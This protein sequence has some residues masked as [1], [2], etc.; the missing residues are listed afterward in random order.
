MASTNGA[1]DPLQRSQSTTPPASAHS[2]T[3][4]VPGV[5]G[6]AIP[7]SRAGPRVGSTSALSPP[8]SPPTRF[9]RISSVSSLFPTGRIP[10]AAASRQPS[11]PD[12][13]PPNP[14]ELLRHAPGVVKSRNGAVLSRGFMLKSDQRPTAPSSVH[15]ATTDGVEGGVHLRGATNFRMAELGVFGVAQPTET[16]LRTILSVLKSQNGRQTVWFCTREEP[17][18]YIGAQPFVLRDAAQ[19][20]RTYALS[21]RAENLEEIEMRLKQDIIKEAAR[22]G[23][24]ILVHEEIS[25]QQI[26]NTWVAVDQVR[27]VREVWEQVAAEGY[28]LVY[29]RI[30]VTRDQSPE[31]RYLDTYAE[32]LASIPTTSSLVFNC[33][34]GVVRTTFAMC[35]ALIVRRRQM[36]LQGMEDPYGIEDDT[37]GKVEE[38]VKAAVVLR[39]RSE[40]AIRDQSLLRL[41]HVLQKSLASQGQHTVL[42]LLSSQP[43]L[44]EN[45]RTALLGQY[46]IVLSLLS[47]LD[48]GSD[49]K[50]L[51][52]TVV[53]HSS[54]TTAYFFLIS[55]ASFAHDTNFSVK[56]STW[57]RERSE[58]AKMISRMRKTGHFF[59]FSPVHDLSQIAKGGAGQIAAS[60]GL[61]QDVQRNGGELIGDEWARQIVRNRSGIILRA[62]MILKNDQWRSMAEGQEPTIRGAINFR[63]VPNSSLYGLSQ[64]TQDGIERVLESVRRDNAGAKIVWINLREEPLLYIK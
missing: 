26:R 14:R 5:G 17:V 4:S 57:L 47:T 8:N 64:P 48:H 35:A 40:Q 59:V 58:V 28:N 20:T 30:P 39:A 27:T 51:V 10:S 41:M 33:G 50:R 6:V 16:G 32:I 62:G 60:E 53:D 3:V 29:H 43:Q 63:R 46:D 34:I 22:Y 9:T 21:D 54:S 23:G 13:S 52:D 42:S 24:V 2:R 55:F 49:H 38:N 56:F 36:M 25:D 12:L 31:D 15:D 61:K 44:L 18:V 7:P 37:K 1:P 19:P 45:L 11:A